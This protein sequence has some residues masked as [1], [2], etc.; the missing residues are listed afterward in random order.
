MIAEAHS[1]KSIPIYGIEC[2]RT[3]EEKLFKVR[4]RKPDNTTST[5]WCLKNW[6]RDWVYWVT[7]LKFQ[8]DLVDGTVCPSSSCSCYSFWSSRRPSCDQVA[9]PL[10]SLQRYR[11]QIWN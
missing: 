9:D 6:S 2:Y 10:S 1:N 4:M 8:R 5:T 7:D 3:A 11:C